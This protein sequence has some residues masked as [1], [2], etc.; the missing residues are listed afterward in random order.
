MAPTAIQLDHWRAAEGTKRHEDLA[1]G[2]HQHLRELIRE[3][4]CIW[5]IG[6]LENVCAVE[7]EEMDRR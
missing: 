3:G 6:D 4:R 5:R 7:F 1:G 2:Q